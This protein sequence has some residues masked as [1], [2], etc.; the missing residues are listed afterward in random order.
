MTAY[1]RVSAAGARVTDRDSPDSAAQNGRLPEDPPEHEPQLGES[2][3]VYARFKTTFGD[4]RLIGRSKTKLRR[5]PSGESVPYGTGRD[6]RGISSVLDG[7]TSELGWSGS[8]A[9]SDLMLAWKEIA[10]AETAEHSHPADITDSVL[11]VQCD[12]TAWATQLRHMRTMILTRIAIEYPDAGI[13]SVRFLA[14]DAPSWK[15][16]SRSIPGRGPRDTYG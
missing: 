1:A 14:P 4:A 3:S 9:K 6:P 13:E 16:G 15:R 11:S 7:L 10:G 2:A 8:L 12:S 5:I